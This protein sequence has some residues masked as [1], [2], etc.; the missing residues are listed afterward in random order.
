MTVLP[1]AVHLKLQ[2][3]LHFT[4]NSNESNGSFPIIIFIMIIV[5]IQIIIYV[6]SIPASS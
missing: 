1:Q 5:I 6:N 4:L 2:P 3:Q